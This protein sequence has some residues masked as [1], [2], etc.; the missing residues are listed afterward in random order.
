MKKNLGMGFAIG[1]LMLGMTGV[2]NAAVI[3]F[4]DLTTRDNFT[5]LGIVDS[6]QGYE[7]GFGNGAGVAHRNFINSVTGW[8]SATVSNPS[9]DP[10]PAGMDGTSYAWN[11]NGPQ[12]LWISFNTPT[13]VNSADFAYLSSNYSYNAATIQMFGYNAN[14]S[15]LYSSGIMT[16]TDTFQT[17]NANFLG[18]SFLELRANSDFTWFSVDNLKVDQVGTPLPAATLFPLFAGFAGL[19][20]TRFRRKK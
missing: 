14:D 5:S 11:W 15:L 10:A 18:V 13:K 1:V 12:S 16:L 9:I 2:A 17:L 3:S 8:A 7:W 19:I 4:E 20:S 6:Y